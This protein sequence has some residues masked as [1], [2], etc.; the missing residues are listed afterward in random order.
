MV[1]FSGTP[2]AQGFKR[3]RGDKK[4]SW[5]SSTAGVCHP[6][7]MVPTFTHHGNPWTKGNFTSKPSFISQDKCP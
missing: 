3:H 4:Y 5:G 1:L 6:E 2:L 7:W